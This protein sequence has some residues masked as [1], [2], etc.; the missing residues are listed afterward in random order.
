MYYTLSYQKRGF[1]MLIKDFSKVATQTGLVVVVRRQNGY[2]AE[3]KKDGWDVI[4][5]TV[6]ADV[7]YWKSLDV[8]KKHMIESGF[9]GL[10]LV[11]CQTQEQLWSE[12]ASG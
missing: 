5:S 9:R 10:I 1:F 12:S 6:R 2:T 8:L 7:R 11:G 3:V 4:C